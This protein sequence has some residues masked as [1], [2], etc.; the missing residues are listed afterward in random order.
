MRHH[1]RASVGYY[2]KVSRK[3]LHQ[4]F[5]LLGKMAKKK[6]QKEKMIK[7]KKND[8]K[9]DEYTKIPLGRKPKRAT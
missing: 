1:L 4:N 8:K 7:I 3:I 9:K 6:E 2:K 5:S